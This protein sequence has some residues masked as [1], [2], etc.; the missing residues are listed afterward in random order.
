MIKYTDRMAFSSILV[1]N[2]IVILDSH[3]IMLMYYNI[4]E[5][6]KSLILYNMCMYFYFCTEITENKCF[7]L[8]LYTDIVVFIR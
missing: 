6:F 5:F 7:P 3:N 2:N 8:K 1:D 4:S